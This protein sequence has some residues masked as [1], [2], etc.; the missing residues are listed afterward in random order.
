MNTEFIHR[1][2]TYRAEWISGK[3]KEVSP[4]VSTPVQDAQLLADTVSAVELDCGRYRTRKHHRWSIML[5]KDESGC[6]I[7]SI[8]SP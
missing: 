3:R 2:N 4:Q 5:Q 6:T 8:E 7:D 1:K